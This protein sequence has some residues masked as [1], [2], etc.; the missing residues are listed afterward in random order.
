MTA[1]P[2]FMC[3]TAAFVAVE[4][5]VHVDGECGLPLLVADIGDLLER[6]LMG[7]IMARM[8]TVPEF[9]DGAFDHGAAMLRFADVSGD[10]HG[11]PPFFFDDCF[12]LLRIVVFAQIR[13]LGVGALARKGYGHRA[14]NSAIAAGDHRLSARELPRALVAILAV[15][16]GRGFISRVDPGIGC[17]WLG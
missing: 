9:I 5:G 14:P 6:G 7:G 2:G 13:D 11:L 16:V 3:G 4:H 15:G 10:E 1:L 12:H 17:F 8:S